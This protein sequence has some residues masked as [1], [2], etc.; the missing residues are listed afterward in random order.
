MN[1]PEMV[2]ALLAHGANV[3]VTNSRGDTAYSYAKRYGYA[4]IVKLLEAAGGAAPP[5][6]GAK[7]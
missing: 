2:E 4:P 5:A 6:A 7:K 1:K 3:G